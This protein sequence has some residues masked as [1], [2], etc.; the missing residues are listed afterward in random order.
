MPRCG[1]AEAKNGVPPWTRG[2]FRRVL[3][4]ETNLPGRCA[5]AVAPRPRGVFSKLHLRAIPPKERSFRRGRRSCRILSI[6][7]WHGRRPVLPTL[8]FCLPWKPLPG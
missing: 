8:R 7:L 3:G 4:R 5:T 1:T 2:D 6:H